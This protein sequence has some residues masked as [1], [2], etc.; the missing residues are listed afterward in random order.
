MSEQKKN[1]FSKNK[2]L[3]LAVLC[4]LVSVGALSAYLYGKDDASKLDNLTYVEGPLDYSYSPWI[5]NYRYWGLR[6]RRSMRKRSLDLFLEDNVN[7]YSAGVY[8]INNLYE[9][10][11][12]RLVYDYPRPN[13]ILGY[14]DTEDPYVKEVYSIEVD[15]MQL[16]NVEGIK[17]D[18]K[19]QKII[20]IVVFI[21]L[22]L[23]GCLLLFK[24][25][26]SKRK[27]D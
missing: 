8:L 18:I 7:R 20:Q 3:I 2:F 16:V 21:A 17:D 12:Y 4:L 27:E 25:K 6:R 10:P 26:S 24:H 19:N 13:A 5:Y 14:V 22:L 23:L 1:S 9:E 11:F 15:G